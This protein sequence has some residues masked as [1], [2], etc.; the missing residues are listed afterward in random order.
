[1]EDMSGKVA[2]ITGAS[3]GVGAAA[4]TALHA[5]GARVVLGARRITRLKEIVAHLGEETSTYV[6]TDVRDPDHA[7]R[8]IDTAIQRF[9]RL[10]VLVANAGVGF[11]GGILDADDEHVRELVDTNLL[12][13]IWCVRAAV[14]HLL[15]GG[16]III[17]SSVAGLRG[18]GDEAVYAATKH[19]L[20]GLAGSLDRELRQHDVRVVTLCP[21]AIATEFAVG[22]GRCEPGAQTH[23]M[24][25][26]AE[27]A[28]AIRVVVSQPRSMRSLVWTMRSMAADN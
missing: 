21:G 3:S 5:A 12:G 27:V 1:M 23:R 24:L 10:D 13:A 28:E 11:Y 6:E 2:V 14:P 17:V 25:S 4:A 22:R 19:A 15:G 26:A 16:D 7:Q 20:V 18:R 8:L 9:G